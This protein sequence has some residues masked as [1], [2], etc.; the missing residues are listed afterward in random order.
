MTF[1]CFRNAVFRSAAVGIFAHLLPGSPTRKQVSE[2]CSSMSV[3]LSLVKARG[4]REE[5]NTPERP[6]SRHHGES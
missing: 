2:N 6:R 4:P 3:E 1:T 5:F